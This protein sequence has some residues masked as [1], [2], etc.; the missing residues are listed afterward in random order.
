M[1]LSDATMSDDQI[2]ECA[3]RPDATDRRRV[4]EPFDC[5]GADRVVIMAVT[6]STAEDDKGASAGYIY[7]ENPL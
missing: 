4:L 2:S 1:K 6:P 7:K 3:N 5:R